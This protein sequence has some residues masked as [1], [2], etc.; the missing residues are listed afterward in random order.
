[1]CACGKPVEPVNREE[2]R[3][4]NCCEEPC[5]GEIHGCTTCNYDI[6]S[7]CQ[8]DQTYMTT[9]VKNVQDHVEALQAAGK[10]CNTIKFVGQDQWMTMDRILV[11]KAGEEYHIG[12]ADTLDFAIT[13]GEVVAGNPYM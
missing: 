9:V 13:F 8:E 12:E 2:D 1:M 6:C 3:W 11:T 4:C 5:H 10:M 7:D